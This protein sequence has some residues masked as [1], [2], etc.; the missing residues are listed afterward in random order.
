MSVD[1][2]E[3]KQFIRDIRDAKQAM[4]QWEKEPVRSEQ[5][6]LRYA[7][8]SIVARRTIEKGHRLTEGDLCLKRLGTGLSPKL[9]DIIVGRTAAMDIPADT[10]LTW[11]SIL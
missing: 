2:G 7:R 9:I 10:M 11:G 8:R 6:A 1:P 4:G 5:E 3:L